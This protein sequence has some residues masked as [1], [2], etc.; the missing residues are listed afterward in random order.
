MTKKKRHNPND[1]EVREDLLYGKHAIHALQELP[2]RIKRLYL[3]EEKKEREKELLEVAS[4]HNVPCTLLSRQEMYELL[5]DV[6]HQ[7]MAASMLPVPTIA[8]DHWAGTQKNSGAPALVLVLDH[9]QDPQ[10]MG[11]IIRTAEVAGA[12]GVLFP[13]RRGAL[14]TEAVVR[15]SAGAALRVPLLRG[16]NL[17][18]AL[19]DL[20]D[21]GFWIVGLEPSS[22]NLLWR[23]TLFPPRLALVLGSEGKGLSRLIRERCDELIALPMRGATGSLNVSAAAAV[24]IFE[25]VRGLQQNNA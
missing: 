13:E 23:E 5:G 21:L 20:Q 25:W 7:G 2:E 8:F 11:A 19:Q 12:E 14:P 10:N 6:K 1:K 15:A 4:R 9:I 3:Q 22:E 16:V 24:G 17:S 18:R